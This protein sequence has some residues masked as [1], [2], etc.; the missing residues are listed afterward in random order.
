MT[1]ATVY[2]GH[3]SAP[4]RLTQWMN[5]VPPGWTIYTTYYHDVPYWQRRSVRNRSR[6]VTRRKSRGWR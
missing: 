2:D 5:A 1:G 6:L 4:T 3:M